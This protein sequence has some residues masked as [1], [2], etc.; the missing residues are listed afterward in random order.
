MFPLPICF[1]F[2]FLT[3]LLNLTV[4]SATKYVLPQ[5]LIFLP[6][7]TATLAVYFGMKVESV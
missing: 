1:F 6:P 3:L 7:D 5:A 2:T 4:V